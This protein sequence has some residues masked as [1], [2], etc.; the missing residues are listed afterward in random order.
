MKPVNHLMR[1]FFLDRTSAKAHVLASWNVQTMFA[2]PPDHRTGAGARLVR[3][4]GYLA[5]PQT[6]VRLIEEMELLTSEMLSIVTIEDLPALGWKA[7]P[8]FTPRPM[9]FAM[10]LLARGAF[11]EALICFRQ[12]LARIDGGVER[13]RADLT[14]HRSPDSRPARLDAY[15]LGRQL[16]YQQGYGTI[17]A[18]LSEGDARAIATQLHRWEA[19]AVRLHKVEHLWEP[20]P[21]PFELGLPL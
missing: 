15:L 2:P 16:E 1:S 12:A 14:R 10:P 11:A 3:G 20:T 17:C 13:H 4:F 9:A 8:M 18:L 21:F 6:Q 19:A 7:L 5:D